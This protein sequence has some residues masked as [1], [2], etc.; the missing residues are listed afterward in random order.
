MAVSRHRNGLEFCKYW[1]ANQGIIWA[2]EGGNR[3]VSLFQTVLPHPS[4]RLLLVV[5]NELTGVDPEI[6]EL[7]DQVVFL[8]MGGYK[9][10][11]NVA[12]AFGIAI[13]TLRHALK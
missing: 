4:V 6:L 12:V 7:C 3:A 5:G 2:M 13:Y 9:G 10:S 11:L 1:K 8:P